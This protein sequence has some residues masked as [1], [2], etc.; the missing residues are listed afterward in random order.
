MLSTKRLGVIAAATFIS[1]GALMG[2]SAASASATPNFC[3]GNYLCANVAAQTYTTLYIHMWSAR[4]TFRGHFELQTP[5]HTT[6]NSGN[7]SN[8]PNGG[9]TFPVPIVYGWYCATAWKENSTTSYTKLG[10][11]CFVSGS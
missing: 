10:Y 7:T 4:Y 11:L 5:E 2:F 6:F 3:N 9:P 1:A 8:G